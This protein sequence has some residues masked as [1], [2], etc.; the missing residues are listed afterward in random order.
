MKTKKGW[1]ESRLTLDK[2]LETGD[3]VDDEMFDYFVGVLPPVTFTD[4]RVQIGE[5]V[6]TDGAGEYTYMTLEKIKGQWVYVG[7]LTK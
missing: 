1:D 3:P 5:P 2:Y 7:I 4:K 6:D